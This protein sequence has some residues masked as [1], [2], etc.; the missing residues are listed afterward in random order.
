MKQKRRFEKYYHGHILQF[1]CQICRLEPD[2]L[3]VVRCWFLV[4]PPLAIINLART[5]VPVLALTMAG[6]I[7]TD[8]NKKAKLEP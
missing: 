5:P 8:Q 6:R 7:P 1:S 4:L 3:E 2:L